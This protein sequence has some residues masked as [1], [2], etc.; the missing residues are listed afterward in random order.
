MD[1]C[2]KGEKITLHFSYVENGKDVFPENIHSVNVI[3]FRKDMSF[4][5]S[6]EIT[7]NE[8]NNF[9]GINLTL[10][11]GS[12]YF[13]CWANLSDNTKVNLTP[14]I[15]ME[16]FTLIHE[17]SE[18]GDAL[19]YSATTSSSLKMGTDPKMLQSIST[20]KESRNEVELE[21]ICSYWT[22]NV[23]ICGFAEANKGTTDPT[24]CITGLPEGYNYLCNNFGNGLSFKQQAKPIKIDAGIKS[25]TSFLVPQ[26]DISD[27]IFINIIQSSTG[28]TEYQIDLQDF[29]IQNNLIP[30]KGMKAEIDIEVDFTGSMVSITVSE[31]NRGSISP[32]L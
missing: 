14:G 21:F 10:E 3:T 17:G 2:I 12:Y 6:Y 27:S 8:L 31:W 26:F 18:S 29:L 9:Q 24:V 15:P 7:K 11:P 22:V 5:N 4:Q 23:Y 28:T 19:F 30:A 1:G 25:Y 20:S 32:V 13:V 16:N